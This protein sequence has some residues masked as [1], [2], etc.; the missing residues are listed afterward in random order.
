MDHDE[1]LPVQ[2]KAEQILI[3][4]PSELVLNY[5]E[6]TLKKD[7]TSKKVGN[8][9]L[10]QITK[11]MKDEK[12]LSERIKCELCDDTFNNKTNLKYH[13]IG[14]HESKVKKFLCLFNIFIKNFPFRWLQMQTLHDGV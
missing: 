4:T 8:K 11:K 2:I 14:E 6:N 1:D 7:V 10:Q 12:K 5:T 13:I 3:E 9:K